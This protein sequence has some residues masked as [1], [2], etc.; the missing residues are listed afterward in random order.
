MSRIERM[1]PIWAVVLAMS[2]AAAAGKTIYVDDDAGGAND[3]S[4]WTDA[5]VYLQDAL[6][7]AVC[8]ENPVEILVAQGLYIPDQGRNQI[9]GDRQ[10]SFQLVNGVTL[11]GGFAGLG[12]TDPDARDVHA[13]A[14]I[15]SGDLS[16]DDVE[17]DDP[18]ELL[19][20]PTRSENSYHVVTSRNTDDTTVL[21]GVIIV[22]GNSNG[23]ELDD[24][25]EDKCRLMRGSGMYNVLGSPIVANCTFTGNSASY[26]GG[27]GNWKGNPSL[28]GCTFV[29]NSATHYGGGMDNCESGPTLIDCTFSENSSLWG[30]GISNRTRSLPRLTDCTFRM[31]EA[32]WYGGGMINVCSDPVLTGCSFVANGARL[33]GG[34]RNSDSSP[35]LTNCLIVDNVAY[36][37]YGPYSWGTL[38]G[39]GGGMYNSRSTA[40]LTNCTLSGNCAGIYAGG[41]CG[42]EST[43]TLTNCILWANSLPQISGDATVSYSNIQGGWPGEG[44]LDAD[45]LFATLG[46]LEGSAMLTDVSN[47]LWVEGDY[48]LRSR[49]GRWDPVR[50]NWV[51][52]SVS[53]PCIDAGVPTSV[54]GLEQ[55]PN[56]GIIN[57]GAYGGTAEASMSLS[58]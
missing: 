54:T 18:Y 10:A 28:V 42:C 12:E 30:G 39:H 58:P 55:L 38:S 46:H 34:L 35:T 15:L 6:G 7:D 23:P 27:M 13:Y 56:G 48:H 44:N 21:D 52:D 32:G 37:P 4:S 20:E 51:I 5:Y 25:N 49:A 11:L 24:T 33:G 40:I 26:G 50:E 57:M 41:I 31:N 16:H 19:T 22:A 9:P 45:P 43:V 8:A 1:I 47:G 53:S 3:G 29:W 17:L 36:C 14:T 2:C